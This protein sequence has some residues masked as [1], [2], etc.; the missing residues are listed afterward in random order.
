MKRLIMVGS[1]LISHHDSGQKTATFKADANRYQRRSERDRNPP[2]GRDVE[3]IAA[4][5]EVPN[6]DS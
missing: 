1:R 5:N 4:F 6:F 3:R 2:I